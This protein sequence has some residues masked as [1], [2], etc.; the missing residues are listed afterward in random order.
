LP[1]PPLGPALVVMC[2]QR[3]WWLSGD[4]HALESMIG[5]TCGYSDGRVLLHDEARG[6]S[7]GR[8]RRGAS[9]CGS[10]GAICRTGRSRGMTGSFSKPRGRSSSSRRRATSACADRCATGTEPVRSSSSARSSLVA[11][12]RN[13][14]FMGRREPTYCRG[15]AMYVHFR[16]RNIATPR[17]SCLH[18]P[19]R[20]GF[21]SGSMLPLTQA[22]LRGSP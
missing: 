22:S 1:D 6:E 14:S 12:I 16:M 19:T 5:R 18:T 15:G 10:T 17:L 4:T 13:R 2:A 21:T 3:G 11:M 7:C 9:S 8:V 20:C